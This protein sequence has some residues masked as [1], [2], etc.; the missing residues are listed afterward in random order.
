[1]PITPSSIHVGAVRVFSGVTVPV[2]GN[3]PTLLTHT[4][5]V[6]GTGTEIGATEGDF[7]FNYQL[8]KT[9]I[10]AEQEFA[11][12]DVYVGEETGFCTF[13]M[14]EQNYTALKLA[15]DASIG[16]VDDGSKTLFYAGG[17]TA[18][19]APVT[20]CIVVSSVRRDNT[21]KYF[22]MVMYKAYTKLG[23]KGAFRKKG[24]T[25][26][27]VEMHCLADTTRNAGDRML[28]W[29]REK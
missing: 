26:Y 13:T 17:G 3:P 29:F 12:V 18:V 4:N 2:T 21:A 16:N 15:F 20:Q 9:E 23:V 1:V 28:Q 24:E 27:D 19:L 25:M 10:F 8:I 5:G 22:I 7:V 14:K 11:P 6:P